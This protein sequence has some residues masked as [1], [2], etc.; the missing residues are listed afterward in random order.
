MCVECECFCSWAEEE[1]SKEE[2]G[3][4][5][6][7]V[8]GFWSGSSPGSLCYDKPVLP[9]EELSSNTQKQQPETSNQKPATGNQQPKPAQKHTVE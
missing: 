4:G 7:N 6:K 8:G 3:G 1:K 2:G 9:G 5:Y